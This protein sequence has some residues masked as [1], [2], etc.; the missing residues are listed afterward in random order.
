MA[1]DINKTLN[2]PAIQDAKAKLALLNKI[3]KKIP[4]IS[5]QRF[6]NFLNDVKVIRNSLD[7]Q[8]G[9]SLHKTLNKGFKNVTDAIT[10][11]TNTLTDKLTESITTAAAQDTQL[12]E[13]L[14]AGETASGAF[15]GSGSNATTTATEETLLVAV[16][17]TTE[18]I[19][20]GFAQNAEVI[21]QSGEE[22]VKAQAEQTNVLIANEEKRKQADA[23]NNLLGDQSKKK[24]VGKDTKKLPKLEMP[25]FP[26]N[27]KQFMSGLGKILK[28]ILNPIALIAGVFMQLLPYILI[29]IAF[30][31][32]F[33]NGLVK[34]IKDKIKEVV[35]T[36]IF[37]V[38]LAFLLFKGPAILIG[39]LAFL[40]YNLKVVALVAKWGL[41]IS[42]HGIKMLFLG[43]EHTMKLSET[44][45]E[46][47]CVLIEHLA[48]K[49]LI[50]LKMILAVAEYILIAAAVII[51]IAAIVLLIAGIILLF[52]LFGDKIIEAVGK[53]IEIFSMVGGMIYDAIIG[54]FK[55][56][57]DIVVTVIVGLFGGLIEAVVKGLKWIFG[58]A[59]DENEKTKSEQ[60]TTVKDG[61]TKD[62]FAE[63]M[64]PLMVT[65]ESIRACIASIAQ[66]EMSK[67]LNPLGTMFGTIATSVMNL[68]NGNSN[69]IKTINNDSMSNAV[70]AAYVGR[71]ENKPEDLNK[72]LRDNV[73]KIATILNSWDIANKSPIKPPQENKVE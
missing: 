10:L 37:Y 64:Q 4:G 2:V 41:E 32:G 35:E 45:F 19:K 11:L 9:N 31:K 26:L 72:T 44:M 51:I 29:G 16:T 13:A 5:P 40:W 59:N 67:L 63:T 7:A 58:G 48:N 61:I 33:W 6:N 65:L 21:K 12:T 46:R 60:E 18:A 68:Y 36:I 62:I 34:P 28:G 70:N 53:I 66:I 57:V 14:G 56:L 30:F 17:G 22:T 69:I 3:L 43:E 1:T 25:K 39:T 54:F 15:A 73:Q 20:E 55:M 24:Q 47:A 42:F 49:A 23:R 52:V 71:M 27:G 38:G 50:A 8:K